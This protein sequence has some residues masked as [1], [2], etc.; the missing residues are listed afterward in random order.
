MEAPPFGWLSRCFWNKPPAASGVTR[1][2]PDKF[3]LQRNPLS[4]PLDWPVLVAAGSL[5]SRLSFE[6]QRSP[7]EVGTHAPKTI[8]QWNR[9]F[10]AT[11]LSLKHAHPARPAGARDG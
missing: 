9:T 8:F 4:P 11:S 1:E 10:A 3:S 2:E 5:D 7:V 6:A